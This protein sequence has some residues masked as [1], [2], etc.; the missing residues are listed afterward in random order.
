MNDNGKI[1]YG[2]NLNSAS[3]EI[4]VSDVPFTQ[5][6]NVMLKGDYEANGIGLQNNNTGTINIT[7]PLGST[8]T[9]AFLYWY[10]LENSTTLSNTGSLNN[11]AITGTLIASSTSDPCFFH[12]STHFFRADV[13]NIV[14]SGVNNVQ[15]N[16]GGSE[17]LID[18]ASLVVIFSNPAFPRKQINHY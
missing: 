4:S 2:L 8:I 18:G 14:N 12:E 7:L 13:T 11:I 9:N 1:N 6:F 15:I 17:T 5:F 16:P 3:E 10:A